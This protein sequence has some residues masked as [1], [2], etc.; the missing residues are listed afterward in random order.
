[1]ISWLCFE[2]RT[3]KVPDAGSLVAPLVIRQAEKSDEAGVSKVI[4]SAFAVDSGWGDV[5][6][7]VEAVLTSATERVFAE[8]APHC[9]VVVHGSRIIGASL[10]AADAGA[11]DHLISGPCILHEYRNRGLA[12]ALLAASLGHLAKLDVKT[13]R[14]LTRANS[15]TA[16]FIY[17][18]FGGS[19]RPFE[20]DPLKL[21]AA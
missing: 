14:G 3:D 17:P 1:M 15:I 7:T 2:W 4:K 20:G 18:K 13:A 21:E 16:R 19:S 6:R 10:L 9:L 11:E 5:N 8:P 12:S